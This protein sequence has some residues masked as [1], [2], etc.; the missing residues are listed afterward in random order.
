VEPLPHRPA[1]TPACCALASPVFFVVFGIGGRTPLFNR[2]ARSPTESLLEALF[3]DGTLAQ[4]YRGLRAQIPSVSAEDVQDAVGHAVVATLTACHSAPPEDLAGYLFVAAKN[5]L[6][7]AID[8]RG[9]L[10]TT[11]IDP[12]TRPDD[13][14]SPD[15]HY[16]RKDLYAFLK[17][18]VARWD[19]ERMRTIVEIVLDAAYQ[20]VSLTG[21]EI[22]EQAEVLTGEQFS[23]SSVYDWKNRGL[24]R[25]HEELERSVERDGR[26]DGQDDP[27]QH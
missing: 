25:L 19:N 10:P 2:V 17:R 14:S 24:R 20:D 18:L 22:A 27:C 6:L 7:R 16:D 13:G 26:G 11:D 23:L 4:I 12:D 9:R 15:R 21:A 3:Q 5:R 1:A 8:A